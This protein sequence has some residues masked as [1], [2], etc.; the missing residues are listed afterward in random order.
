MKVHRFSISIDLRGSHSWMGKVEHSFNPLATETG[1]FSNMS[2]W[3]VFNLGG[4]TFANSLNVEPVLI[5]WVARGLGGW[6]PPLIT[7]G[8]AGAP[9][10][11]PVYPLPAHFSDHLH[12]LLISW[13]L[14]NP[15]IWVDPDTPT[16]VGSKWPM[17]RLAALWVVNSF[18]DDDEGS[19][20]CIFAIIDSTLLLGSCWW[21][22]GKKREF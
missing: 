14:V 6:V 18:D 5:G 15:I 22:H 19:K 3:H 1:Q 12:R 7:R 10:L 11:P 16:A 17:A 4:G 2:K 8:G 20:T 9:I 13:D 21:W